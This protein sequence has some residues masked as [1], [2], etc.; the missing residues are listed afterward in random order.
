MPQVRKR[1]RK[2]ASIKENE[3][4]GASSTDKMERQLEGLKKIDLD[5]VVI[6]ALSA[7][8]NFDPKLLPKPKKGSSKSEAQEGKGTD[9]IQ[10]LLRTAAVRCSAEIL[11]RHKK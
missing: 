5:D 9:V 11:F 4:K 6:Q 2:L 10:I 1:V 7:L 3:N 8:P